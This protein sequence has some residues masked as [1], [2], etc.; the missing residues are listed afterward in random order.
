MCT[1]RTM[2]LNL[3]VLYSFQTTSHDELRHCLLEIS[4]YTHKS[5]LKTS[6]ISRWAHGYVEELMVVKTMTVSLPF[7]VPDQY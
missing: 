6:R 5:I 2:F 3:C 4:R 1:N 7:C